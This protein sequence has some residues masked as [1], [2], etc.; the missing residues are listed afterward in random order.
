VTFPAPCV[1]CACGASS[2]EPLIEIFDVPALCNRLCASEAEAF[3][4]SRG[5]ILLLYC[6]DCGHIVNIAFDRSQIDYD[7]C[8]ENSLT[9]SPRYR[10]YAKA[11]AD[12][13]LGRYRLNG[14]R[15]IEIGCGAGDFLR[16]LCDPGNDGRGYDPSQRNAVHAAGRGRV[17]IVGRTFS[18]GDAIGADFVCCRQVLEHLPEPA[19]FLSGLSRDLDIG[20][21][22]FFEVPNALFV[23]DRLSVW[24]I[25]HEHVSYFT[26]SSIARCFAGAGF[27]VCSA[28]SAFDDQYLWVEARLDAATQS[29]I[30]PERPGDAIYRSFR[31]RF[32]ERIA[33]WRQRVEELRRERRRVVVWGAGS[34]GVMFLNLLRLDDCVDAVVDINPR[35]QGRFVPVTG[36]RIVAP[37]HL[38]QNPPDLVVVMNPEYRSEV[39]AM[40]AEIG[41]FCDVAV[42]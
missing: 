38:Q 30:L 20:A 16:L 41:I 36:H 3:K 34:K 33:Q 10:R 5:D 17:E 37:S 13:L 2:L 31:A 27:T 29:G 39:L 25:I 23:V 24:D 6:A 40:L 28:G 22:T 9:F 32:A 14:K 8:Y 12:R 42:A 18:A 4:V 7:D 15:I 26:A 1:C 35:K 11:T 19:D 21:M